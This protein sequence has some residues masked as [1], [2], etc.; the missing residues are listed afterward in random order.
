M[1]PISRLRQTITGSGT[2]AMMSSAVVLIGARVCGSL[3]TLV[4][5]LLLARLTT[6]DSL[7]IAMWCLSFALLGS[8]LVSMNVE[9]GALRFL[10][11]HLSDGDNAR[12]AG[13]VRFSRRLIVIAAPVVFAALLLIGWLR[14]DT[15]DQAA[16]QAYVVALCIMPVIALTRLYARNAA[17]L[18]AVLAGTLPVMLIRPLLFTLV[19]AVVFG[20]GLTMSA[21]VI[22]LLFLAASALTAFIQFRLLRAKFGFTTGVKPDTGDWPVWFK[23]GLMLS[24]M[25]ILTEFRKD[26]IITS[27][28]FGMS[29]EAVAQLAIALALLNTLMFTLTAIDT[30]FSP[31]VSRAIHQGDVPR[32]THLLSTSAAFKCATLLVLGISI[33][34]F[35]DF[36][37]GLFGPVYVEARDTFFIL[38]LM[39]LSTA[40]FGPTWIILNILGHRAEI[41]RAS[42][43][44]ITT[45]VVATP[46]GGAFFGLEGAA[47]GASGGWI[48]FQVLLFIRC[49]KV[50][51]IDPSAPAA[52]L[53]HF[54]GAA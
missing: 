7:G 28:A 12:A 50:A 25:L 14:A 47:L 17:A 23:T 33:W 36:I 37:L 42:L 45:M 32:Y 24:P 53:R 18:D 6:P 26:L 9:S 16:F 11:R 8:V 40:I 3:L 2:G 29:S 10:V 49:R 34:L 19:L 22:M 52:A 39:P 1:S 48:L 21:D 46:M 54:H 4:Y 44:G 38:F 31:K 51:G 43:I 35:R 41:L 20:L 5:T 27:A 30:S 13:F 15:M